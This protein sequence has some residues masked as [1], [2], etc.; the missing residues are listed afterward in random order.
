MKI[1]FLLI[2]F[3][4]A[5]FLLIGC[6]EPKSNPF[7][8][9]EGMSICKVDGKPVIRM[10]GT[11]VCPHCTWVSP[12]F[13][14]A[15]KEYVSQGKIVAYHWQLDSGDDLLSP[16]KETVVPGSESGIYSSF[17][18]AGT[19]P[20]YVFGCKYYRIGNGFENQRN[21]EEL[22]KEKAEFERVIELVLNEK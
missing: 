15:V 2:A 8:K 17:N 18:P 7:V 14:E 21:H 22:A 16:E 12:A 19:V 3:L 9:A 20:T 5:L 1:K 6:P 4:L 10:Y 11:T 13:E